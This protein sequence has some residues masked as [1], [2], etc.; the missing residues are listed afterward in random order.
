MSHSQN[1]SRHKQAI[2]KIAFDFHQRAFGEEMAR[3]NFLPLAERKAFL[4]R[5]RNRLRLR[6]RI[7]GQTA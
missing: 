4:R 7:Q 6:R 3:I 1:N 5:I 2:K